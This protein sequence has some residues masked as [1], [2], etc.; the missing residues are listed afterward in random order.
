MHLTIGIA[1][2]GRPEILGATLALAARQSVL[3]DQVII[4]PASAADADPGGYAETGLKPKI[5][6]GA[7]GLPNQRNTILEAAGA[8]DVMLFLDDDFFM[9]PDFVEQVKALFAAHADIAMATGHVLADGIHGPGIGEAEALAMIAAAKPGDGRIEPAFSGYGC[10]MAIR[11]APVV[12]QNLR[13][14]GNLP[15][16]GWLE[17][18][19]FTRRLAPFGRIVKS[20]S[21]RG[22][23]LGS[24][25]GRNS[26]VRFGYSQV[27][28][29]LYMAGKG[30]LSRGQAI[31]HLSRNIAKNIAKLPR[32]EAWIDRRGRLRGNF[33]AMADLVRGRMSP[34]RIL[35]LE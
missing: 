13:F 30:S 7:R 1:T 3:P 23:H 35:D 33:L 20:G 9:A 27:A 11:M 17:D 32:P 24:K 15:L 31:L 10:N 28:N 2:T 8:T 22:V 12:A 19:D 16:Y 25:R 4:C 5:V 26:G 29:P 18:L 34:G 14:D 6:F 21:L